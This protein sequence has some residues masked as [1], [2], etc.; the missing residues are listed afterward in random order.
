MISSVVR[1]LGVITS[2]RVSLAVGLWGEPGIG[3]SHAAHEVLERIPCRSVSLHATT[4]LVS[5]LPRSRAL[6]GW[7]M[8]Q[9]ERLE[10]GEPLEPRALAQA[11]ATALAALAPIVLHLEDVHEADPERFGLI[12]LLAEAI[13]RTRGVGLLVTSRTELPQ[14]FRNHRLEPLS[15]A[16]TVV[17]L[18]QELKTALPR[19]GLEWVFGR[20]HGNPLFALEFARYLTRQGF[21]WSD[22]QRWNWR[23]PPEDFLP[24][25]VEALISQLTS[26]LS[27]SPEIRSALEAQRTAE[28]SGNYDAFF[29]NFNDAMT[30]ARGTPK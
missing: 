12:Q 11:S 24:V 8:A 19:E 14:P 7:V 28:Q 4:S 25:T 15:V 10:R 5:A 6:P 23:L 22:G 17:L 16:E 9:L 21:L 1:Q 20:T 30:A 13:P 27:V 2:K 29:K 18:E 3:K 26:S